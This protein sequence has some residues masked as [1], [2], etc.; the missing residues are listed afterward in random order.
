MLA[1][2]AKRIQGSI[3]Y[4][5]GS[6][7]RNYQNRCKMIHHNVKDFSNRELRENILKGRITPEG[8]SQASQADLDTEERKLANRQ[9]MKFLLAEMEVDIKL[10]VVLPQQEESN[11]EAL[12]VAT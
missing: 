5:H 11:P 4:Y 6:N 1:A 12:A 3:D 9:K 2:L 7:L 8:L 10:P